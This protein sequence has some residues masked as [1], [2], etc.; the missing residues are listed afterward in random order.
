MSPIKKELVSSSIG[1]KVVPPK[2]FTLEGEDIIKVSSGTRA[3][4]KND[5]EEV[6]IFLYEQ[7]EQLEAQKQ[8]VIIMINKLRGKQSCGGCG[9]KKKS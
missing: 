8:K 1:I 6:L 9:D 5:T 3:K 4:Q 2:E 7:L